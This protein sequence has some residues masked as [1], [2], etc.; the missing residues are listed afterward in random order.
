MLNYFADDVLL[1]K[2]IF[3]FRLYDVRQN[4]F[5][6]EWK[7]SPQTSIGACFILFK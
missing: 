2:L 4:K 6:Q 5:A 7:L 1:K 3:L